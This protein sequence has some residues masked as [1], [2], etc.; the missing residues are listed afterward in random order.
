[1]GLGSQ[2]AQEWQKTL[3]GISDGWKL[4]GVGIIKDIT[5]EPTAGMNLMKTSALTR[6]IHR[7]RDELVNLSLLI[8][9]DEG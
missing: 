8:E 3:W 5:N 6:F 1:V 7:I 9:H 4:R 2:K